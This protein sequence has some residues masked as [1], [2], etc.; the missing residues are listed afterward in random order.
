MAPSREATPPSEAASCSFAALATSTAF[1]QALQ[2]DVHIL[3]DAFALTWLW[4]DQNVDAPSSLRWEYG[5]MAVFQRVWA[6]NQWPQVSGLLGS[7]VR[8]RRAFMQAVADAFLDRIAAATGA[9]TTEPHT[10]CMRSER[11]LAC[12][13][14]G[15]HSQLA[16]GP[17]FA[18]ILRRTRPLPRSPSG[19]APCSMRALRRLRCRRLPTSGTSRSR[20][21][22]RLRRP[23]ISICT[24]RR[25]M[26][27]ACAR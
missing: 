10:V 12:T 8:T 9:A 27:L 1:V 19:R 20:C 22:A 7:E 6:R 15:M 2:R 5:A 26:S 18:S 11:S 23:G 14:G 25:G 13:A 21:L 16:H 3:L 24:W 4:L 17:P